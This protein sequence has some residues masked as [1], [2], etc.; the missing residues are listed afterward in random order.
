MGLFPSFDEI[1]EGIGKLEKRIN[2]MQEIT[3]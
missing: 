2:A 1:I 3:S